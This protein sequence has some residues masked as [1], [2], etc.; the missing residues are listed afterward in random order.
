MKRLIVACL[1]NCKWPQISLSSGKF[2][3][4]SGGGTKIF[5]GGARVFAANDY[6][7]LGQLFYRLIYAPY[8]AWA[9]TQVGA[10]ISL[11][12][13]APRLAGLH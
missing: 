3:M 12:I 13:D 10:L 1:R 4:P 11:M 7:E 2:Y 9:E 6:V 5:D 8:C